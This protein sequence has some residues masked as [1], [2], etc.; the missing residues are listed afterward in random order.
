MDGD[1]DIFDAAL[2]QRLRPSDIYFSKNG[3]S[4][5]KLKILE[6][7]RHTRCPARCAGTPP[8]GGEF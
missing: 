5:L 1:D 8:L 4:D 7:P 2:K 3:T 6:R